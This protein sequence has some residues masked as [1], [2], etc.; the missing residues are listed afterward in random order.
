MSCPFKLLVSQ[1]SSFSGHKMHQDAPR[2]RRDLIIAASCVS[3]AGVLILVQKLMY[4]LFDHVE[5]GVED[6]AAQD[7]KQK[8][9]VVF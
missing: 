7:A 1:D 2:Y 9:L 5:G 3:A 6:K 8:S 4:R